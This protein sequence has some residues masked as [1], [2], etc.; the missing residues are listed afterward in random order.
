MVDTLHIETKPISNL[1]LCVYV[2]FL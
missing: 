1:L 2:Y